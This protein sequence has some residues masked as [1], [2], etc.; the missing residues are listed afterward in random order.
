MI[1]Y[2]LKY[3][4][5]TITTGWKFMN[6]RHE[7]I[8]SKDRKDR[9]EDSVERKH[10][11]NRFGVKTAAVFAALLGIMPLA[12]R[13]RAQDNAPAEK[14]PA[15][16]AN[17]TDEADAYLNA[18]AAEENKPAEPPPTPAPEPKPAEPAKQPEKKPVSVD[19]GVSVDL[20]GP[21]VSHNFYFGE[22]RRKSPE[23]EDPA[24]VSFTDVVDSRGQ[25]RGLPLKNKLDLG[26]NYNGNPAGHALSVAV[27]YADLASANAGV[28]WFNQR[29]GAPFINLRLT[30]ELSVGGR[31]HGQAQFKAF[32]SGTVSFVGYMPS[33]V[34][35]SH[36][37]GLAYSQPIGDNFKL[38]LAAMGGGALSHPAYDDIYFNFVTG[39][40]AEIFNK[41]LIYGV[42]T[43]YFAADT[44]MQ[45][46]YVGYYKPKFQSVEVGVQVLLGEY[47]ARAYADIGYIN[48]DYGIYNRY[49]IKG[50]RS[51]K[52]GDR[53]AGDVYLAGG[54]T[55]WSKLVG[56]RIDPAVYAG[57]TLV[58]GGPGFNST[59]TARFSHLQ[60]G[61][62]AKIVT[63]FPTDEEP[64]PYGFG[65][66]SDP[67]MNEK[68][69]RAKDRL[70]NA[71]SFTEFATSYNNESEDDVILTARFLGAF[72]QQV[73][74]NNKAQD[75][76]FQGDFLNQAVHDVGSATVNDMFSDMQEYVKYY[77]GRPTSTELP[78]NL[79]D[80][81][82]VC[83]G[84]H[85][86]MAAFLR[87]NGM[88][89]LS[90]T[91]N[92]VDGPHVITTVLLPGRTLLLSYGNMYQGPANSLDET[93]RAYGELAPTFQSQIFK[94]KYKGT[95]LTDE[96][97]LLHGAIGIDNTEETK[98][99]IG[100]RSP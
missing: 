33:W 41:V 91:V 53:F 6:L 82:A 68:I 77:E 30:P 47:T 2:N 66:S 73:A 49:M 18:V 100:V 67:V 40:S 93:L 72:L 32:Y 36:S 44:P 95:L 58:F 38:R 65:R 87:A 12:E 34:Y 42:P 54:I 56:G 29:L 43:C 98:N 14:S 13:A 71:S 22:G 26:G 59:N 96:G 52:F 61:I 48:D 24:L 28:I 16:E 55:E 78:E 25:I 27:R 85:E 23:F 76:L 74:Y 8:C 31:K 99:R 89:A 81:I 3:P 88:K 97:A 5:I 60:S 62:E 39:L 70:A 21:P 64:G 57:I 63:D 11:T 9:K 19:A 84:I 80:G 4:S 20:E 92:T 35:S 1:N 90:Q 50:T 86:V 7:S 45:T 37:I 75:A 15:S 79:K 83:A 51:V 69:N 17:P 10:F 94:G 46:A